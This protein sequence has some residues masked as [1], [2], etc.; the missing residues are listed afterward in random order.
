MEAQYLE[1]ELTESVL[2][3]NAASTERVLQELR[4][5]GVFLTV[6][7]FGTGY[8]SLS[9]LRQFPIHVLKIDQSFI[10]QITADPDD[11]MI[12]SA[13]IN[14]GKSLKYRVIAEGIET[15]EQKVYLRTQQ[16]AEGQGYLFSRP[17]AAEQFA[18]L[19]Q[20]GVGEA[21]VH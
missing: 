11:S 20:R 18:S 21:V 14:M 5:M 2:M 17:V 9:Y 16:C 8:S 10:H 19:L 4:M 3:N 15:Q 7:D 13:I 12:V 1:L 6:D